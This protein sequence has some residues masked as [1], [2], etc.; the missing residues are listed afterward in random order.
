MVVGTSI[1][2]EVES[3]RALDMTQAGLR[4]SQT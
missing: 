4:Q 2:A 1:G 3:L